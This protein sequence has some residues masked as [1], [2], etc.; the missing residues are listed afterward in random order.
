MS[1]PATLFGS[2]RQWIGRGP[3]VLVPTPESL[4]AVG[5]ENG[6]V[7]RVPLVDATSRELN[8]NI[9]RSRRNRRLFVNVKN[10]TRH[11]KPLLPKRVRHVQGFMNENCTTRG[12]RRIADN[13]ASA[14][15]AA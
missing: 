12:F 13:T 7:C 6:E 14:R 11:A 15:S 4:L 1:A 9:L 3:S 10:I 2:E 5:E 8:P